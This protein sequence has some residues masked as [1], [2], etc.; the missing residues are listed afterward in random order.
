M[1]PR[2]MKCCDLEA[3]AVM[4]LPITGDHVLRA[5]HIARV[6]AL[7]GAVSTAESIEGDPKKIRD[8][9]RSDLAAA[10]AGR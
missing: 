10:R 4:G 2:L 6:E 5:L 8:A 7:E 1:D 9:L 3:H